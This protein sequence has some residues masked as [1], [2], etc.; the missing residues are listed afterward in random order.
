MPLDYWTIY[1]FVCKT[2]C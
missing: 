1:Y 2:F